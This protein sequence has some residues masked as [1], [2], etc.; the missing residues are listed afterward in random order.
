[1]SPLQAG[2]VNRKKKYC[3]GL[4]DSSLQAIIPCT[5]NS[6]V[7]QASIPTTFVEHAKLVGH[8]NTSSLMLGFH[9]F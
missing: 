3:Y 5:W 8:V 1:M 2:T 7:R 6:A 4:L 9:K